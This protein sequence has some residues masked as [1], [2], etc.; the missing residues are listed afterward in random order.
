VGCVAALQ[1]ARLR[2]GSVLLLDRAEFP[3]DKTCA[4]G[5]SP[6]TCRVL[7]GLGL[8]GDVTREA[9]PIRAARLVSPGGRE[10]FLTSRAHGAVLSR[11]RF[12]QLLAAAAVR[13]GVAASQ[14]PHV[15]TRTVLHDASLGNAGAGTNPFVIGVDHFLK[16]GV[17]EDFVG[18]IMADGSDGSA[19]FNHGSQRVPSE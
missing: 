11:R 4:G 19:T 18:R 14:G 6:R 16:V 9:Y 2:C 15:R 3:R 7:Q 12:D 13:E 10:A 5:L 8:W 17:G 1:A